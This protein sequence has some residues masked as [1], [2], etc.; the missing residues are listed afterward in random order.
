MRASSVENPRSMKDWR[1]ASDLG[2]ER[3]NSIKFASIW[4]AISFDSF[5]M[6]QFIYFFFK[7]ICCRRSF[8]RSI[9]MHHL[10]PFLQKIVYFTVT[11]LTAENDAF[12]FGRNFLFKKLKKLFR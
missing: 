6:Y 1:Y 5:S 11:W 3:S 7:E 12:H 2:R 9:F 10:H 4:P 8:G